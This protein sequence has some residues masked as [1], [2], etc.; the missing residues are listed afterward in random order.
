MKETKKEGSYDIEQ[1]ITKPNYLEVIRIIG[2]ILSAIL[3]VAGMIY[4]LN[5][6]I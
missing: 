2:Y 1:K 4:I 6:N 5:L 3:V